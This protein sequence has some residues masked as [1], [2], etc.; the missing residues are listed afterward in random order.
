MVVGL[1]GQLVLHRPRHQLLQGPRP[2][3]ATAPPVVVGRRGAVLPGL[4]APL[5]VARPTRWPPAVAPERPRRRP[6][7]FGNLAA[8]R[9]LR[10]RQQPDGG[11]LLTADSCLGAWTWRS[12]GVERSDTAATPARG[13]WH[14]D[15]GWPGPH[16]GRGA[17]VLRLLDLSGLARPRARRRCRTGDRRRT[18]ITSVGGED[19]PRHDRRPPRRRD[20][21]CALS[22]ALPDLHHRRPD[23]G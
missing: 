22:L 2:A 23:L 4:P 6:R 8:P 5:L 7:P 17:R 12:A 16:H 18:C 3:L 10:D 14:C 21:L 13:R 20:L 1:L 11:L 9:P 19:P 15:V